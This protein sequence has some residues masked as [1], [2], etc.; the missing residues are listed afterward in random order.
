MKR[1]AKIL[2]L[3]TIM[4]VCFIACAKKAD[5][6]TST[7]SNA[8]Y[9]NKPKSYGKVKLGKYKG[10]D[11]L[12]DKFEVKDEDVDMEIQYLLSAHKTYEEVNDRAVIL[13]DIANIDYEGKKDG[14]AFEGGSAKAYDLEI[15]SNSFIPGFEDAIIGMK[16][17]ETKDINLTFPK[18]YHSE[19][20]AGKDVV[21]TVKL[22]AIKIAKEAVLDDAWVKDY[23]NGENKTVDELKASIK[24]HMQENVEKQMRQQ[25]Q[26]QAMKLVM[27]NLPLR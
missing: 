5:D 13:G 22:N 14:V 3:I 12:L 4:L 11:L 19:D 25:E 26:A 9:T 17:G 24:S 8:A 16:I 1:I 27:E 7:S 2:L 18:H 20:L 23:T 21:F 10:I 6:N 15:G